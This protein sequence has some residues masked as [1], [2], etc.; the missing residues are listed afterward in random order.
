MRAS[1]GKVSGPVRLILNDRDH[2]SVNEGGILVAYFRSAS[3]NIVLGLCAATVT[4]YG[5]MLSHAAIV[6][7]ECGTPCRKVPHPYF[8]N[9]LKHYEHFL[10]MIFHSCWNAKKKTKKF[11]TRD[12]VCFGSRVSLVYEVS[13]GRKEEAPRQ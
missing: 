1:L 4:D 3:F 8:C 11:E 5:G 13:P 7:R 2:Q 10:I 6:A 9:V 12:I